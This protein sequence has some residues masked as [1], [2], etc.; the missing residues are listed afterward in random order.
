MRVTLLYDYALTEHD[1][2]RI[3]VLETDRSL[4]HNKDFIISGQT[5]ICGQIPAD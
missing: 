4:D 2:E 5:S 3:T 1:I